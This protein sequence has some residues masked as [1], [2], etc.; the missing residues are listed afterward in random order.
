MSQL[1]Q[2]IDSQMPVT[3]LARS[4]KAQERDFLTL[5]DM[6]EQFR[7]FLV[8]YAQEIVVLLSVLSISEEV[9]LM[10]HDHRPDRREYYPVYV[11]G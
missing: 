4:T 6:P 11:A 1:L 5:E 10:T 9:L 3:E 7:V 8:T 2:N